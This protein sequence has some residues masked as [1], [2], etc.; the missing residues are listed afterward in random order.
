MMENYATI[1]NSYSKEDWLDKNM[2][3]VDLRSDT[4]TRPTTEM[5]E[6]I[7][8]AELGDD[9]WGDDPTV[10]QL[11]ETAALLLGKEAALF[12]PSG[13]MGNL[14]AA[15]IHCNR[16]DELILGDKSHTFRWEAGG[17]SAVGGIH[18]YLLANRSDGTIS[19]DDIEVAIRTENVHFPRTRAIFLENTH[20][21]CGGI[22]IPT[23]Y[24]SE[25]RKIADR[26]GL[27]IHLDGARLFNAAA[28]L[29][30]PVLAFTQ[31]ADSVMVCLSKG[32]C[33][34]VGSLLAGDMEFINKARRARKLL[35]GGMR[36][37]GILA[38]AGIIALE[39]MTTRLNEDHENARR[40]ADGLKNIPEIEVPGMPIDSQAC[41]TNMVFF[42][43]SE[44]CYLTSQTLIERLDHDYKIKIGQVS[45]RQMRLVVHYWVDSRAVDRVL[46]AFYELFNQAG[47]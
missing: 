31:F 16:G 39:K 40:L 15:L 28:A 36:Q 33:A 8:K 6:A 47:T 7:S 32:L 24:F 42:K 30:E 1:K 18:P 41:L 43:L 14:I 2:D 3:V 17:V 46:T 10:I 44:H 38:A 25:V 34:P 27:V 35:G 26:H 29:N 21:N 19:L 23:S 9:V 20:N 12:L 22:A 13:T 4:V 11:Q 45:G 37:V 5:M